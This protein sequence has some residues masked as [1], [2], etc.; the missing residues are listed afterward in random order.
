MSLRRR[1]AGRNFSRHFGGICG[2]SSHSRHYFFEKSNSQATGEDQLCGVNPWSR[3]VPP[4]PS[5][6]VCLEHVGQVGVV[7]SGRCRR[8]SPKFRSRTCRSSGRIG[9]ISR[10]NSMDRLE[11]WQIFRLDPSLSTTSNRSRIIRACA[12]LQGVRALAPKHSFDPTCMRSICLFASLQLVWMSHL[13]LEISCHL[14][15]KGYA[16]SIDNMPRKG[17]SGAYLVVASGGRIGSAHRHR[18]EKFTNVVSQ[19]EVEQ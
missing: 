18:Q 15:F 9:W 19:L 3:A 17:Q 11:D 14:G 8:M 12:F 7:G 6:L 5:V 13:L 2:P 4:F 1:Y 16:C 10:S